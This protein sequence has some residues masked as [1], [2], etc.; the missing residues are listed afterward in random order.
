MSDAAERTIFLVVDPAQDR[1][2]VLERVLSATK[3]GADKQPAIYTNSRIHVF[4]GVDCDNTDTSAE[5]PA[6]HRDGR[7]F[8]ENVV[9]PLEEAGLKFKLEMSWSSDWY[10]SIQRRAKEL[11]PAL[12]ML[13][14]LSKP[15]E[16][17]RL[18]NESIWRLMRTADCP[19]LVVRPNPTPERSV[20]LSAIH[21]QA[22]KPEYQ[23]LNDLIVTR[24]Q[25]IAQVNDADLHFVNAY[26]DTLNYPDRAQLMKVTGVDSDKI[27]VRNG[28]PEDVIA[29]VAKEIGADVVVLGTQKRTNRWRG[30]TSEKI[31]NRVDCDIL[32]IN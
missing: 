7:W 29:E 32:T 16:T 6:M 8:L 5:N 12:I 30:N 1:P 24:S 23:R 18:F 2:L 3:L 25:W 14:L 9:T 13:P 26:W 22:H 31:I 20:V 4:I 21:I 28:K 19:V 17:G 15:S 27:H 11:N 10:G